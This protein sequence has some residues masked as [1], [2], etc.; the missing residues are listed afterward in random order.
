MSRGGNAFDDEDFVDLA[1]FVDGLSLMTYDYSN[2]NTS[3]SS[4]S[5]I[6]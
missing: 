2:A 1:P 4:T 3:V 5:I 6:G